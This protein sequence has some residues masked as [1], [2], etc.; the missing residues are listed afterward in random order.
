MLS[1]LLYQ[2]NSPYTTTMYIRPHIER[3]IS[4]SFLRNR[5]MIKR[6]VYIRMRKGIVLPT[7]IRADRKFDSRIFCFI[8]PSPEPK[9]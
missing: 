4:F 3:N 5:V 1:N 7:T 2:E 8:L 9:Y 6:N